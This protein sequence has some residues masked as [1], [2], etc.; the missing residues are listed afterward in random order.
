MEGRFFGRGGEELFKVMRFAG[1]FNTVFDGVEGE[2][3]LVRELLVDARSLRH[4]VAV[5]GVWGLGEAVSQGTKGD[6]A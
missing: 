1:A 6:D 4:L 2:S 3:C 5:V